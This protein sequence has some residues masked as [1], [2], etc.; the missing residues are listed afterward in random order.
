[1]DSYKDRIIEK[2]KQVSESNKGSVA[3]LNKR[4]DEV[5]SKVFRLNDV[6]AHI[7]KDNAV[8]VGRLES[9]SAK[10]GEINS[11]I[12]FATQAATLEKRQQLLDI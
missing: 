1:M 7:Q 6:S 5:N 11:D 8:L 2:F 12:H 9:L 3:T 4:I 10:L